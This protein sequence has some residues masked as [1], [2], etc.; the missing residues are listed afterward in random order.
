[1]IARRKPLIV[2]C[3]RLGVDPIPDWFMN[4]VTTNE[5]ILRGPYRAL[6][7]ADIKTLEG[8]KTGLKGDY[9]IQ[10][11]RGEIYPCKPDTFSQTYDLIP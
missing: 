8:V 9:I 11:V 4:K 5:I 10:G 1:M 6:Q 7:S 2:E 3:F